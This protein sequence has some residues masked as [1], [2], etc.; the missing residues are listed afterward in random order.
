MANNKGGFDLRPERYAL[1]GAIL[2]LALTSLILQVQ[3]F[4]TS[5]RMLAQTL[6]S[7]K[8]QLAAI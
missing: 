6:I 1:N 3:Q 2:L 5:D 4:L 7:I 8:N